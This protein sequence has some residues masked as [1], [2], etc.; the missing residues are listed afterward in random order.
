MLMSR[1]DAAVVTAVA[2]YRGG[3]LAIKTPQ[4]HCGYLVDLQDAL[5]ELIGYLSASA[6]SSTHLP[7]WCVFVTQLHKPGVSWGR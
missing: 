6:A 2:P 7:N 1:P 5:E 3:Y 4:N